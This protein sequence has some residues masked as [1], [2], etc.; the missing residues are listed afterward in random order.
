MRRDSA[1]SFARRKKCVSQLR[2]DANK[3][4]RYEKGVKRWRAGLPGVLIQ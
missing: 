4:E 1:L 2:A 3:G